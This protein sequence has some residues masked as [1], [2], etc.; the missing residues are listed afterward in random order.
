MI[1]NDLIYFIQSRDI[2]FL[3]F[4]Q[5]LYSIMEDLISLEL[6]MNVQKNVVKFDDYK[7]QLTNN[8]KKNVDMDKEIFEELEKLKNIIINLI[9]NI[10]KDISHFEK[11]YENVKNSNNTNSGI[12]MTS[13]C[14]DIETTIKKVKLELNSN[15]KQLIY[16]MED[17]MVKIHGINRKIDFILDVAEISKRKI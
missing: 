4:Y 3:E 9:R 7:K 12:D 8:I 14:I 17:D 16:Q 5:D 13:Y 15:K 11:F 2:V 10:E 1:Q 6:G